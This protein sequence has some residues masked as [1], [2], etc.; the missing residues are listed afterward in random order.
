MIGYDGGVQEGILKE[1]IGEVSPARIGFAMLIG[2]SVCLSVIAGIL[3]WRRRPKHR[4][5]VERIFA[6]FDAQLARSGY[7]R[8]PHESPHGYLARLAGEVN[9][10]EPLDGL[11][12]DLKGFLYNPDATYGQQELLYLRSRLRKL[13]FKLAFRTS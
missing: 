6:G 3:F 4:D 11:I 12:A 9:L 1:L 8:A 5:P 7:P 2:G 10:K 13:R